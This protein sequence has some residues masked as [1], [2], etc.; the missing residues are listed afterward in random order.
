MKNL[1]KKDKNTEAAETGAENASVP[2]SGTT[3]G[4]AV[5]KSKLRLD[6]R[7]ILIICAACLA[8]VC[9]VLAI[10]LPIC[11]TSGS[12]YFTL[13]YDSTNPDGVNI[14]IVNSDGADVKNGWE[15][16][17]GVNVQFRLEYEAEHEGEPIIFVNDRE[18]KASEGVYSFTMNSDAS[19]RITGVIVQRDYTVTF[20]GGADGWVRY[21][22]QAYDVSEP[23]TVRGGNRVTF[24]VAVS[25]YYK[26][27]GYTV[28]ANTVVVN[29]DAQGHYT[30]TVI[31]NTTV[32]VR[33]L[34]LE[35]PFS[36]REAEDGTL[37]MDGEGT[38][39]DPYKIRKPIDL[40][41][42][43]DLFGDDFYQNAGFQMAYYELMN[44][45]D[46]KGE[47]LYI[48]GDYTTNISVFAG[49]FN[50]NGH[51]ISDYYIADTIIE[52][53]GYQHVFTPFLG[54]FGVASATL[55]GAA[56]IYDLN[57]KNFEIEI[58]HTNKTGFFAGGLVGMGEGVNITNCTAEG[59][60]VADADPD[61]SSVMGGLAGTVRAVANG[62]VSIPSYLR[63]CRAN[64]EVG[65]RSGFIQ[66]AG[67]LVG[68][69][70]SYDAVTPAY[71]LNSY[72]TGDVYGAVRTG[73]IV[74]T[75]N[76]YSS[77]KNCY[78]TGEIDAR[79]T[80]S[81]PGLDAYYHAYSGGI[82]GYVEYG[83]IISD[84]FSVAETYASASGS[85]PASYGVTD[86]IAAYVNENVDIPAGSYSALVL[87][88]Y[89]TDDTD[90]GT[91]TENINSALIKDTLRWN[92]EDWIIS[93]QSGVYPV[94]NQEE[95]HLT[96]TVT[97]NFAGGT[98]GGNA[99]HSLRITD[100]YSDMAGLYA[101]IYVADTRVSLPQFFNGDTAGY[102][103][104]GYYFDS[105]LTKRIPNSYVPTNNVT[106]YAK[107]VDYSAVAGTYYIQNNVNGSARFVDYRNINGVYS[108][109]TPLAKN[110]YIKLDEKGNLTY[111]NGVISSESGYYYDG[112]TLTLEEVYVNF[113]EYD[114]MEDDAQGNNIIDVNNY[115]ITLNATI[116]GGNLDIYDG[117]A[118]K[119]T[120]LSAVKDISGAGFNY[121]YYYKDNVTY[122]FNPD[123]TGERTA[124]NVTSNFT[125]TVTGNT[126]SA[127]AETLTVGTG[128]NDIKAFDAY[129]GTWEKSAGS[130]KQYT[131]DGKGGY[132]YEEFGYKANGEK[133]VYSSASGSY[134]LSTV[135]G[136]P[137][138]IKEGFLVIDGETYYKQSSF[139]GSW[140]FPEANSVPIDLILGGISALGYG[141]AVVDYG[142]YY[143]S[144]NVAYHA[145]TASDGTVSIELYN[146]DFLYGRLRYVPAGKTLT[147]SI[148]SASAN[149]TGTPTMVNNAT[150]FLFDDFK[151]NWVSNESGLELV[152]F[153]GLGNYELAGNTAHAPVAGEITVNG[154]SAGKYTLVS[155]KLEGSFVYDGKNY[156]LKY[157]EGLKLVTVTPEGG[158]AV[159]LVGYDG[160]ENIVLVTEDGNTEYSFD[161]RGS[162]KNGGGKVT[163]TAN[164][165]PSESNYT[166]SGGMP[167]IGGNAVTAGDGKFTYNGTDLW[168]KNDFTGE[169]LYKDNGVTV[170]LSIAKIGPDGKGGYKVDFKYNRG[171]GLIAETMTGAAFDPVSKEI[172]WQNEATGF[173][174]LITLLT[175]STVGDND[176]ELKETSLSFA[177]LENNRVHNYIAV[178]ELDKYAGTYTNGNGGKITFDGF[179]VSVFAKGE[180]V[181][182][183]AANKV[184][185]TYEYTEEDGEIKL[186]S[187][188]RTLTAIHVT[189]YIFKPVEES[190]E[191]YVMN[192]KYYV[193]T[194]IDALYGLTAFRRVSQ[195][196]VD[197]TTV[198][199][200]DGVGGLNETKASDGE[201][202]KT[203]NYRII[204]YS[205]IMMTYTL[206]VTD[207][208]GK[209]YEGEMNMSTDNSL[210]L[211]ERDRF[212]NLTV[213]G[214][215]KDGK[216]DKNVRYSFSG[217]GMGSLTMAQ[218]EDVTTYNYNLVQDAGDVCRFAV[219]LPADDSVKY[220]GTLKHVLDETAEKEEDKDYWTFVLT[221]VK[222]Q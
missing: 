203:Y 140:H 218:G 126:V 213:Y 144:V 164:G 158:S 1:F 74:G 105:E 39:D 18:V 127:G 91:Q 135:G 102:R 93:T 215:D 73:G 49:N 142:D 124:N 155:G 129:Y 108:L 199:V 99:T 166:I 175:S 159:E 71:V 76:A 148:I 82:A 197:R 34:E 44:D 191:A 167:L 56:Q 113:E 157:D 111:R 147:G 20:D 192:G 180:A 151:G 186:S 123:M 204:G 43:A 61:W 8:V 181:E 183:D 188:E 222:A 75:V 66:T 23:I 51:T 21:S 109:T 86:G 179:G 33:N 46:M 85:F 54:L 25:V 22:S 36:A 62:T 19:I 83:A 94:V 60:I 160:W 176:E 211:T 174:A 125:Y 173:E 165:T 78:S 161:G 195:G 182:Y 68:N 10:V 162:V 17:A 65:G 3:E 32:S 13:S 29:P 209:I 117:G 42:M 119:T 41:A 154:V 205:S 5:T 114:T 137:V 128:A 81:R 2:E 96:Y 177:L 28:V 156:T 58:T 92:E 214:V 116:K 163:V 24:D 120:H 133:Q 146:G 122:L 55:S 200:F 138:S 189:N 107:L 152:N 169:W 187:T 26:Q 69:L 14:V 194:K 131:F 48:I 84:C 221:E 101:G 184:L 112:T 132:T 15:V 168:L 106:V 40:Y 201:V 118:Y 31:G 198:Y 171:S 153:N 30:F 89:S 185:Q 63:S 202:V 50:G 145:V 12:E 57:L 100:V 88:S 87:N 103:T 80:E 207:S 70:I 47:R 170:G 115:Y 143:G 7:M 217:N 38:A 9:V 6:K 95:A 98:V 45:I 190:S 97:V 149:T 130:N 59:R 216:V 220:E 110:A 77:V 139:V 150:F 210:R 4:G 178:K 141:E 16:R 196:T 121:G 193:I 37:Y 64:V 35:D 172:Y 72:S 136:K 206:Y 79:T 90:F 219:T 134:T 212:F 53:S 27:E 67:G 52:Q 208:D 104:Y 11:L